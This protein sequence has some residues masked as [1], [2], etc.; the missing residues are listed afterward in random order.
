MNWIHTITAGFISIILASIPA[1]VNGQDIQT[2]RILVPADSSASEQQTTGF[3]NADNIVYGFIALHALGLDSPQSAGVEAHQ[4]ARVDRNPQQRQQDPVR[5]LE[6]EVE[7]V[8]YILNGAGIHGRYQ[9]G[10]WRYS[11]E[12]FGVEIPESLHGNEGL[13]ATTRGAELHFEY[14][15]DDAPAGFF[16]GPEVGIGR[17]EVTHRE[18]GTARDR[19]QYSAGLRGGYR[20]FTGLEDLYLAPVAGLVTTLNPADMEVEGETFESGP[21]TPFVTVGIGWSFGL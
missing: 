13:K 9:R 20:W 8:A 1:I 15:F 7:P 21:V 17:F 12:L 19:I 2:M 10:G 5:R 11:L 6:V 3:M 14:F 4:A 16:F 18:T